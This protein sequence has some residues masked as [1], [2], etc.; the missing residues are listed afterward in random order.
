MGLE[1]W[2]FDRVVE[3]TTR[4]A[5]AVGGGSWY[6]GGTHHR[7]N[8]KVLAASI[9]QLCT[10][11]PLIAGPSPIISDFAECAG[12]KEEI[13]ATDTVFRQSIGELLK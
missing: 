1:C 6:A 8:L 5:G 7:R 11:Y 9:M 4:P 3:E 12:D 2:R 10:K 13:K